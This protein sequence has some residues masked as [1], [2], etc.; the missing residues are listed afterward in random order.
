MSTDGLVKLQAWQKSREFANS[1]YRE[2]IPILPIDE[3]Y[4]LVS[5]LR[6]AATSIPAN[7]A[8]GHGRFYYQ[9]NIQFCY[10][11]RGS[12]EEA[13]SHL[14]IAHDQGYIPDLIFSRIVEQ[15][16]NLIQLINGY[17]AY[18]KK[19]KHGEN[20]PGSPKTINEDPGIYEIK[21]TT[22]FKDLDDSRVSN[23]DSRP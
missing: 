12:T 11:A 9:T 16:N 5:Q 10:I 22:Y 7:I 3:K 8:E 1:V 15:G 13:L 18:L 14:I 20:E 17:I 21:E 2:I 4:N 23:L 6:R 19:S